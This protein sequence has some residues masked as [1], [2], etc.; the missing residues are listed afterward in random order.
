MAR[1]RSTRILLRVLWSLGALVVLLVV[2]TVVWSQVGVM[3]AE[4]GPLAEAEN[5]PAVTIE[6][7]PEGVVLSPADGDSEV[8]LV[9]VPGAKVQPEAYLSTLED[10]AA[11]DGITVVITRPWLNLAFFDPRG[12]DAFTSAAPE[13][14]TWIVGGH[15]LGGVRACQLAADADALVLFASYCA[16]DLSESALPVL[17]LSGSED[18]LSTPQKIADTRHLLPESAELIEIDGASHASFGA[19]G[20][21]AGDGTPAISDDDMR[22]EITESVGALAAGL[23]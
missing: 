13:V 1:T 20:P 16:N 22:A 9:F 2:G 18:G 21:Q 6:Q 10:L 7:T 15:S 17:S 19:Y 23:D 4:P 14:G 12:L 3:G 5:N 8:G 11:D